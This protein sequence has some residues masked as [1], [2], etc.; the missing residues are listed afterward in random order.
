MPELLDPTCIRASNLTN[1]GLE[2]RWHIR[3]KNDNGK[4]INLMD[5]KETVGT[6]MLKTYTGRNCGLITG[7]TIRVR[8]PMRARF[9]APVQS[10]SGARTSSSAMGAGSP[11]GG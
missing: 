5:L 10:G 6:R 9:S 11:F 7:W 4:T 3:K 1:A 8:I 2:I